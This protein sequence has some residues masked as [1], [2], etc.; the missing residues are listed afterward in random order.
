M[1][2]SA[3][4]NLVSIM[5]RPLRNRVYTM[6][7]RAVLETVTDTNGMQVMKLNLL[8]GEARE[9]VENFQNFGFASNAPPTSEC[10]VVAPGGNRDHL[11]V[12]AVNDRETRIKDLKTGESVFYNNLGDKLHLKENRDLQGDIGNDFLMNVA[13]NIKF[14]IGAN[15]FEVTTPKNILFTSDKIKIQNGTAEIIDLLIQI[16][17]ALSIEPFIINKGTFTEIQTKLTTFKVV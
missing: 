8:A 12:V 2:L 5:V 10:L 7:T 9:D 17:A 16:T 4:K 14:I 11:I 6:I 13:K 15:N 3:M 1:S